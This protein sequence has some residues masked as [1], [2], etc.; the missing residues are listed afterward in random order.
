M[1]I[2]TL[3]PPI[4]YLFLLVFSVLVSACGSTFQA[5]SGVAQ[6]RQAL[7]RGDY[8]TALELFE[9]A[10][11][12]DPNYVF[13]TELREGTLSFLG[14]AQYLN[15][16]LEPAKDTLQKAVAQHKSDNL[17]RLYLG[18]TQGR[19][20]DRKSGLRDIETGMKGISGFLNYITTQFAWSFGQFWDPGGNLRKTIDSNLAMIAK[21]D[22]DWST[23]IA[24]GEA[25]AMNVEQEEDRARQD[26]E[27]ELQMKMRR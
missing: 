9:S 13:G 16:Q 18:L 20:G 14:R 2:E 25:L 15:G 21:G 5:G 3:C 19:L 23:L 17:A 24:N 8:S 4:H 10:A 1:K 11:Q 22:F 27:R 7:F 12:K 6:G 26:E